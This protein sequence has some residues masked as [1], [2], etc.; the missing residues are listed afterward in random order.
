[1]E[2][3]LYKEIVPGVVDDY[4]SWR[5]VW[6]VDVHACTAS[7]DSKLYDIGKWRDAAR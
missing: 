4:R 3:T 6:M 5:M 1:M 7:G 2:F